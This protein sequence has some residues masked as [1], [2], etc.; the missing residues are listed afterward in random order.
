MASSHVEAEVDDVT[1]L[2]HVLL[3]LE[4]KK[5]G[6]TGGSVRADTDEI[7]VRHDLGAYEPAFDIR[8]DRACSLRSLC[9]DRDRPCTHFLFTGRKEGHQPKHLVRRLDHL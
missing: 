7:V 8:V 4:P 2:H 9:A 5:T 1:F 6:V 3:S